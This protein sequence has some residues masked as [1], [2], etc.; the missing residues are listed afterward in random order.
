MK[1]EVILYPDNRSYPE[2]CGFMVHEGNYEPAAEGTYKNLVA[3]IRENFLP[4]RAE[5]ISGGVKKKDIGK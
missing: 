5:F 2:E 3:W 1:Y 4:L